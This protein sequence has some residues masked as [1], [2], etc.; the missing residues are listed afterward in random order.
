[1][2]DALSIASSGLAANQ[3]WIDSIS[4]NIANMQTVGFKRSQVNFMDMVQMVPV[5]AD[6]SSSAS[7]QLTGAGI[8]VSHQSQVFTPGAIRQT[9]N[10]LDVAIAGNG[11]FEV[12]LSNGEL[13]YTRAGR[14]HVD[15]DGRL[16]L[17]NGMVLASDLRIPP[18][19]AS[20]QIQADG[21]V[22]AKLANSS[23]TMMVGQIRLTGFGNAE[24]LEK[25]NEG[26]YR[27]TALSGEPAYAEPGLNGQGT[28]LQS[29]IEM[30]NV[31]LIEEMTGL[32][33]AQRAYQLNARLL[34]AGDQIMETINNLR[35]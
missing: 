26:L 1:M 22:R 33:L 5:N 16:S 3:A 23:E 32:V 24:Q 6:S 19:A 20:I 31:S 27:P 30:S 28:L 11:F 17:A 34:Q 7:R 10:P 2:I 29:H 12:E 18:D 8:K 21:V 4:N 9:T 35:R 14:F 25:I 15:N 13:A